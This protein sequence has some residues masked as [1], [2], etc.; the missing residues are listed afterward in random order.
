VN[1][2]QDDLVNAD[3]WCA[4]NGMVLNARKCKLMDITHARN[5]LHV[6]YVFGGV[7]LECVQTERLLGV[8]LSSDL[9]WNHQRKKAAQ[10]L[11][12]A[13]RSLKGCT[14]RV[15][16]P[17]LVKPIMFMP[18]LYLAPL[19]LDKHPKADQG[20]KKGRCIS[21][22]GSTCPPPN[23]KNLF[24]SRCSSALMTMYISKSAEVV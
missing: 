3:V 22:T 11:G 20:A 23:S 15:T 6:D 4:N 1:E 10:T 8:H 14:P 16:Y 9:K 7:T 24:P 13:S 21:S 5:P 19:H 18:L 2:L 12:Y 17:T